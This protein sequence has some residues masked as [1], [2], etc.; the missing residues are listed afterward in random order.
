MFNERDSGS[1][2]S[3]QRTEVL[4]GHGFR[5]AAIAVLFALVLAGCS[6]FE[7]RIPEEPVGEVPR[8][9]PNL[10]DSVVWNLETGIL[11]KQAGSSRISEALA[12][13]LGFIL[14][15]SDAQGLGIDSLSKAETELG[16]DGFFSLVVRTDS[17]L[18]D[19]RLEERSREE[20]VG[21]LTTY[22]AVPYEV[23]IFSNASRRI[24]NR[25]IRQRMAGT[26]D[27]T[28]REQVNGNYEI[29]RWVDKLSPAAPSTVGYF[30]AFY[31]GAG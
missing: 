28:F 27:L 8:R 25:N 16:L 5:N 30:I 4:S 23:L 29:Y 1:R 6:L 20:Q 15:A 12:D 10:P 18:I 7:T 2:R 22:F 9:T 3:R 21:M 14:D 26:I 13:D 11:Y 31:S 24:E 19:V 17:V